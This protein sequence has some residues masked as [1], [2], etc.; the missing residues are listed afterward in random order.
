LLLE[1]EN[2]N[3]LLEHFSSEPSNIFQG[4]FKYFKK[5][6]L[7]IKIKDKTS[8]IDFKI[9]QSIRHL[10]EDF[11]Y[12]NSR[13]QYIDSSFNEAVKESCSKQLQEL[14]RKKRVIEHV[15]NSIYGALGEQKVVKELEKLPEDFILINDFNCKFHPAIYNRQENDYIKSVQID[16]ILVSPSGI[17]LIET[18]NWSQHSLNNISLYS[19]VQQ[20]KRTNF[21]LYKILN[22]EITGDKLSISNHHWGKRKIPIRNLIVLINQKPIVE[23]QYVK[24]LTINDLLN[25]LSYFKPCFSTNE[26]KLIA[27]YLLNFSLSFPVSDN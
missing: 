27:N 1:L 11:N 25:Y 17:F 24:V 5:N 15:N 13:Y 20:I 23:F 2:L 19:P 7:K 10:T 12:T 6:K 3:Y 16:H 22:E 9:A 26:T 4:F 18:K 21:A 14:D 8:S